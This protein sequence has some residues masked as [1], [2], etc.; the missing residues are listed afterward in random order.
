MTNSI[1]DKL[2]S[3]QEK[4]LKGITSIDGIKSHN[5]LEDTE[6]ICQKGWY[7]EVCNCS[8]RK[9]KDTQIN[10][11]PRSFD[12]CVVKC[13]LI[14]FNFFPHSRVQ[15]TLNGEIYGSFHKDSREI[16]STGYR[17]RNKLGGCNDVG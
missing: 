17:F 16:E 3:R 10:R 4:E 13:V 9:C 2:N 5:E 15:F 8:L 1:Q 6:K 12:I 14:F 7:G 11:H